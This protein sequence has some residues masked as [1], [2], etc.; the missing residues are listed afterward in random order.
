MVVSSYRMTQVSKLGTS[1]PSRA[2]STANRHFGNY[3]LTR[4]YGGH[5][6]TDV[7]DPERSLGQLRNQVS[8]T[9]TRDSAIFL[10]DNAFDL[11][12]AKEWNHRHEA[13][14]RKHEYGLQ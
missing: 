13:D 8:L 11:L 14:D 9:G 3:P 5:C 2:P 6:R 12:E 4:T 1:I 7:N 10:S